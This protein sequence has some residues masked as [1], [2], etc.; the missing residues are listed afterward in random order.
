M[1]GFFDFIETSDLVWEWQIEQLL[2]TMD[3]R[4]ETPAHDRQTPVEAR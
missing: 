1:I 4:T 3:G 2:A